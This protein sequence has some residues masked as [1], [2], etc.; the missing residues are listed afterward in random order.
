MSTEKPDTYRD[1]PYGRMARA[2]QIFD[3]YGES[4]LS[5]GNGY[6]FAGP[7]PTQV[8]A[9]HLDGL[10]GL[11]WHADTTNDCFSYYA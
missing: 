11:G 1:T 6:I 7:H 5:T 8:S 9:E 4:D 10:H 3:T 2:M